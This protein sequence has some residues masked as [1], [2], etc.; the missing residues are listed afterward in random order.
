MSKWGPYT[1]VWGPNG[2]N[3]T[4]NMQFINFDDCDR[5]KYILNPCKSTVCVSPSDSFQWFWCFPC[6]MGSPNLRLRTH[7]DSLWPNCDQQHA[8][9]S[10]LTIVI[11]LNY[12]HAGIH[13]KW[14]LINFMRWI[15]AL[16]TP[17]IGLWCLP[18]LNGVLKPS[19]MDQ[20][21]RNLTKNSLFW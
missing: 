8:I 21:G 13:Y 20:I 6:S 17:F 12:S 5:P 7:L 14:L 11:D 10:T 2:P 16:P 1:F 19:F 9:L 3:L 4:K 15:E 18:M